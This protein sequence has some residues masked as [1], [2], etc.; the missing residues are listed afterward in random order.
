MLAAPCLL[1]VIQ[2]P[3]E[4]QS[5]VPVVA[6]AALRKV[7]CLKRLAV[8]R[9]IFTRRTRRLLGAKPARAALP[10][11]C[12]L[13][14]Q[15]SMEAALTSGLSSEMEQFKWVQTYLH[16]SCF[17]PPSPAERSISH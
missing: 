3:S 6:W 10:Q 9:R 4:M 7:K 8:R 5:S 17:C 12:F 11:N 14:E 2:N 1:W 16:L 15:T 13:E